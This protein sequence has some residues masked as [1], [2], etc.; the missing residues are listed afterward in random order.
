[1]H[2]SWQSDAISSRFTLFELSRHSD[3]HVKAYKPFYLLESHEESYVLPSG[4]F[5]MFYVGLIPPLWFKLVNPIIH[6]SE[7]SVSPD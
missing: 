7:E 3:H 2:H 1:V 5:G 4:Y 6:P